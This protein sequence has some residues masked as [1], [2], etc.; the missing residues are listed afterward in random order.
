M[1][2]ERFFLFLFLFSAVFLYSQQNE[3]CLFF[4]DFKNLENWIYVKQPLVKNETKYSIIQQGE[5]TALK[6]ES[7][8]SASSLQ[9]KYNF[10][11]YE[12]PIVRW[13]WKTD[14]LLV[15]GDVRKKKTEDATLRIYVNFTYNK[16]TADA[17][18]KFRYNFVKNMYG[19]EIPQF[20]LVYVIESREQDEEIYDSP[21]DPGNSKIIIKRSG[22]KVETKWFEEEINILEDYRRA[23]G[24]DP[25]K[26]AYIG[27]MCDTDNTK[28]S[29]IS[30]LDYIG[31]YSE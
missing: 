6:C 31:V 18:Y 26:E 11:V 20:S 22:K 4:D 13:R 27:I 28:E 1:K 21:F 12:Y 3:K 25:Q 8:N 10:N 30:F 7:N 5:K 9:S 23:F 29:T 15:T 17:G 2:K 24:R 19:L 16:E 14:Q